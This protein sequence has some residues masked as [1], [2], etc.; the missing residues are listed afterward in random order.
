L[1]SNL[2]TIHF[3]KLALG[4]VLNNLIENALKYKKPDQ[5]VSVEVVY[6]ENDLQHEFQIID[7]GIG[8]AEEY[9]ELIFKPFKRLHTKSE[10][11]GSG[12]GLATV[13]KIVEKMNGTISVRSVVNEGTTFILTFPKL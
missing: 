11:P 5:N 6:I 8:I 10:Y 9:F 4:V 3:S 13:K 7:N 12:L 1:L 2:P